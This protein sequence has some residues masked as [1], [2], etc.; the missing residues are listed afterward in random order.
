MNQVSA[1][2]DPTNNPSIPEGVRVY[3]VGDVHGR[4]DL[5]RKVFRQIDED[6]N[7]YPAQRS[8]E[9]YVGDYIDRGPS[10]SEVIQALVVRKTQHETVYLRGNHE[11]VFQRFLERPETLAQWR[12]LGGFETLLSYGLQVP[13][14]P[15]RSDELKLA[16]ALHRV[17]PQSHLT[18]LEE[19]QDFFTLGDYFFAHA[20][21]RPNVPLAHQSPR[22]LHWIREEFLDWPEYFEKIIVHGHTPVEHPIFLHN[23]I[24]IDTGAYATGRL[25][26][27]ILEGDKAF[28]F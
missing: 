1:R 8:I 2:S 23:R 24:N 22:D 19:L 25:T 16:E 26:C 20:G 18:W 5:L 11:A 27:L 6:R 4:I 28:F 15:T 21:V 7:K 10:S 13:V 17:M 9:V 14:R 3:A 12:Q